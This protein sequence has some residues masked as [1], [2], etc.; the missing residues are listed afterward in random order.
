MLTSSPALITNS[1]ATLRVGNM[2]HL[3]NK[4]FLPAIF[5]ERY[6]L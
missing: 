2:H 3:A 4:R 1:L 6:F 5:Y